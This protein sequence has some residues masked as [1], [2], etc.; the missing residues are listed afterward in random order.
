MP[1]LLKSQRSKSLKMSAKI[2]P[3]L[4]ALFILSC[5]GIA[6]SAEQD[7]GRQQNMEARRALT[8]ATIL[9][10]SGKPDQANAFLKEKFPNGPPQGDLAV[11]YYRI[12]AGTPGGWD[13][14]R[15]GLEALLKS[16]RR[17]LQYALALDS[18]LGSKKETR[19]L[20]LKNLTELAGERKVDKQR[21]LQTWREV[22]N[23]QE[24]SP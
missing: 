13:E 8:Q 18:L 14:A 11:A 7:L 3:S 2:L 22:L 6:L 20:A 5:A 19:D 4:L 10:K 1:N 9:L 16:D 15:K 21:V 23:A 12:I 24:S 17:N